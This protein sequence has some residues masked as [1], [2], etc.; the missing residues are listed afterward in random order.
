MSYKWILL[1]SQITNRQ[2]NKKDQEKTKLSPS[3]LKL[4][5][6]LIGQ[7]SMISKMV[8]FKL[9]VSGNDVA[10]MGFKGADIGNKIKDMEYQNFK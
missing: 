6:G 2:D 4:W 1:P 3:Q 7:G 5:A 8:R 10:K 9:S